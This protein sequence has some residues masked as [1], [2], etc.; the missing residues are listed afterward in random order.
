MM[1]IVMFEQYHR[2][3][4]VGAGSGVGRT[5]VVAFADSHG[6]STRLTII[7]SR[8]HVI[9]IIIIVGIVNIIQHHHEDLQLVSKI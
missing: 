7:P 1:I 2:I 5:L 3:L 4:R 6:Q 9:G 8:Q